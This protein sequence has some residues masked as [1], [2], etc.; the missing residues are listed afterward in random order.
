MPPVPAIDLSTACA[1]LAADICRRVPELGHIDPERILICL[2]RSRADGDHGVYARIAPLRFAAGAQEKTRRRGRFVE[3][4][5]MPSLDHE[6][7]EILYLVYLMVPRFLRL[8]FEEKLATVIHELYH[9]AESCNGDLRRFPGRNFAHGS[10][11]KTYNRIIARLQE[12]Y[13]AQHPDPRLLGLLHLE[14]EAWRSGQYRLT[15][16]TV[17]LPRARLVA[18]QRV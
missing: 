16:L 3:T 8:G 2:S 6:G 11:R 18:R 12:Y 4:F 15:G 1:A 10:S 14:E 5:R 13:L 9:I 17:P 7:R